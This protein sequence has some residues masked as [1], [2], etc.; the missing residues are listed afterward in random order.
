VAE[1]R[2]ILLYGNSIVLGSIGASLAHSPEFE[3]TCLSAPLP[4]REELEAMAPD[5]ILFDIE[6]SHPEAAFALLEAGSDL[7]LFGISP[8]GN[9]V[10]Q[11]SG[12][13][14][15]EL[16]TDELTALMREGSEVGSALD[17][18]AVREPHGR[19][20][21]PGTGGTTTRGKA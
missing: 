4:T 1:R 16:S 11:W 17:G 12:R 18:H 15:R 7:L 5:V 3:L 20:V 9:V 14:Y 2:R 21:R 8:D 6:N 13:Q 10:R 19:A